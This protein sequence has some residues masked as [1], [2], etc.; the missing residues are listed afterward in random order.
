MISPAVIPKAP[1]IPLRPLATSSRMKSISAVALGLGI[2]KQH[3]IKAPWLLAFDQCEINGFGQRP[4]WRKAGVVE[5]EAGGRS[6]RLIDVGETRQPCFLI[7]RDR[8]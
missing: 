3:R 6:F 2:G 1:S 7:E 5:A 8:I 4:G